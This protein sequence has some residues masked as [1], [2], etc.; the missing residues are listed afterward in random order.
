MNTGSG[1]DNGGVN[2]IAG[3]CAMVFPG[4]GHIVSGRVHRGIL[5]MIG[6]MGLFGLGLFVGGIDAIDSKGGTDRFWFMGQAM[7]GPTA[8]AVN[9]VHQNHFKA[10]DPD[11]GVNRTG[12]PGEKRVQVTGPRGTQWQW[13]M[14]SGA[15]IEG[16]DGAVGVGGKNVPGLGRLNEIAMLSCTL[17]GMLNLII[18]LDAL[19]PCGYGQR[20][21]E[22]VAS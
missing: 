4:L 10:I 16:A 15:E 11:T 20:K 12:E 9:Y 5:A 2:V 21:D 17:A 8:F 19:L 22:G 7:V 14:M 1:Q 6:V 3:I 13:E 18:F